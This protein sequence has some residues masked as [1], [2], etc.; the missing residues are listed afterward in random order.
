MAHSELYLIYLD[1]PLYILLVSKIYFY[2][3]V[4]FWF[5]YR[6]FQ[7]FR[8]T[9]PFYNNIPSFKIYK[10]PNII[11][12][13]LKELTLLCMF[14]NVIFYFTFQYLHFYDCTTTKRLLY[15]RT[16][17]SFGQIFKD[18]FQVKPLQLYAYILHRHINNSVT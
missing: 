5:K 14:L 12:C 10:L 13:E 6:V 8:L 11:D 2:L 15:L 9:C 7:F 17:M 18:S 4:Y 16:K 3:K 1:K